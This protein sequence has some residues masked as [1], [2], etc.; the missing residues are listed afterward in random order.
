MIVATQQWI[1][2]LSGSNSSILSMTIQTRCLHQVKD[3]QSPIIRRLPQCPE[4]LR[5]LTISRLQAADGIRATA[6]G[7][8]LGSMPVFAHHA[9]SSP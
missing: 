8:A 5:E 2:L 6:R 9:A 1:L 3:Y 7:A 4:L